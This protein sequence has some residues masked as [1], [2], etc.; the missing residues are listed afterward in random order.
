LDNGFLTTSADL[1][2]KVRDV[3][4]NPAVERYSGSG[5]RGTQRLSG[6]VLPFA[7]AHFTS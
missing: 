6:L 5:I 7:E 4:N 1:L 2:E 3:E